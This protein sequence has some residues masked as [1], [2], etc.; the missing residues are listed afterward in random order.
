MLYE[1]NPY[2]QEKI[3]EEKEKNNKIDNGLRCKHIASIINK[4]SILCNFKMNFFLAEPKGNT[5]ENVSIHA[6]IAIILF[7]LREFQLK[8]HEIATIRNREKYKV[9]LNYKKMVRKCSKLSI[10][11][12]RFSSDGFYRNSKPCINCSNIINFF[13]FKSVIFSTGEEQCPFVKIPSRRLF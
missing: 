6:E 12:I 8:Y 4:N 13:G 3:E 5:N 9:T 10:I 2:L 7:L 11:V 1:I